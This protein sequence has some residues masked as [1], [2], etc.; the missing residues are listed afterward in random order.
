M[1]AWLENNNR[2]LEASLQWLRLRLQRLLPEEVTSGEEDIS[3]PQ[4]ASESAPARS[5]RFAR[6][7]GSP[8][9][10]QKKIRLLTAGNPMSLEQLLREATVKREAAATTEPPP[11][12]ILLANRFGLSPFERD[13][14]LLCASLEFDPGLASLC[15]ASTRWSIPKLSNFQP[16]LDGV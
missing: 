9:S 15:A 12:L 6:W 11:A 14:L 5:R 13:T 10:A 16:C 8:P 2:Y 4:D 1:E 3:Q 7:M